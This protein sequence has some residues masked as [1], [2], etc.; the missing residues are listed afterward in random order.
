MAKQRKVNL[1]DVAELAGVS[2]ATVSAVINNRTGNIRVGKET[3][4]RIQEALKTTGY[5]AN[6]AARGLAG[7]QNRIIAVFT[8]NSVFPFAHRNFYYP[9]LL[10]IEESAENKG[11]DLLFMTSTTGSDRRRSIYRGGSNRLWLADGAILLGLE[12]NEEEIARLVKENYPFVIIGHRQIAGVEPSYV[13]ADY[14]TATAE[15]VNGLLRKGH[16][17]IALIRVLQDTEPGSDREIGFRKAFYDTGI[18]FPQKLIRR[19]AP[20]RISFA[21]LQELMHAGVTACVAESY[22]FAENLCTVAELNNISIPEDISIAVL[23]GPKEN[24]NSQRNWTTFITPAQDMAVNAFRMLLKLIESP[25]EGPL[26]TTLPCRVI[27]GATVTEP[28]KNAQ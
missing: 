9:F 4:Q 24:E 1:K 23:G 25:N 14:T 2:T 13:A 19:I 17:K 22:S 7:A 3:R 28:R 16:R 18:E 11:Y 6:P 10:A 5:V 21:F 8:Y 15:I 20:E 12:K 26:R 27:E